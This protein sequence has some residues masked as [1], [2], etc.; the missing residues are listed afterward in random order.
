MK[1]IVLKFDDQRIRSIILNLVM[2]AVK[3]S[4]EGGKIEIVA[5]FV[6]EVDGKR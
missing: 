5:K 2:N 3:F 4:R 1:Q 6:D